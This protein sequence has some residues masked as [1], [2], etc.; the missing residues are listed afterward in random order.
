[1]DC[2]GNRI[3]G[4]EGIEVLRG[5]PGLEELSLEGNPLQELQDYKKHMIIRIPSLKI[6]DGVDVSA[7]ALCQSCLMRVE[8]CPV[9]GA[10][11][12]V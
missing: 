6:L 3:A 11:I 7:A 10:A 9:F 2:S 5:V 1:M 12:V 4:F 8:W